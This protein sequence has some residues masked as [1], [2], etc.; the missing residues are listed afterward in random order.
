MTPRERHVRGTLTEKAW[1]NQIIELATFCGWVHYH[2]YDSRRSAAGWPDLVLCR[3]PQLIFV[4]LKTA[5]GRV[6]RAQAE[7]QAWLVACGQEFY[8]WRPSDFEIAAERLQ[9]RAA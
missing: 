2:T 5:K 6:T 1:Q 4:E 9:R 8:V 7:W 3:P